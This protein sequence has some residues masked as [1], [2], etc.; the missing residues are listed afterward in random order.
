MTFE[1][2]FESVIQ[3]TNTRKHRDNGRE[4]RLVTMFIFDENRICNDTDRYIFRFH[5]STGLLLSSWTKIFNKLDSFSD[6]S[7]GT[8][9][10]K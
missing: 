3:Q 10:R 4:L 7:E 9:I 6:F 5:T 8:V 2:R 1:R